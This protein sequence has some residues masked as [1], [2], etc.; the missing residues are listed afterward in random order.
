MA[1]VEWRRPAAGQPRPGVRA[2]PTHQPCSGVD[3]GGVPCHTLCHAVMLSLACCPV[4]HF[5]MLSFPVMLSGLFVHAIRMY[6]VKWWPIHIALI[7][8]FAL[9]RVTI[10]VA[11]QQI[12]HRKTAFFYR[13][14]AMVA[15]F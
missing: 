7:V 8:F 14:M 12:F 15:H 4:I 5:A 6:D 10:A 3:T 13:K 9:K 1:E 11:N 2:A